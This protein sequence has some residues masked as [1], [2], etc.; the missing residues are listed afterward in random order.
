MHIIH[1][2]ILGIIEGITEFLPISSTGHLILAEKA[3]NFK[4]VQDV[5]TVVVQS[6]AIAAVIWY[7]RNDLWQRIVGLARRER[8]ALV[9]WKLLIIGTV[10]AGVFGLL[11]ESSMEKLTTPTVVAFAL[12]LGGIVLWL[13]DRKPVSAQAKVQTVEWHSISVRRALLVGLGQCVAIIP[14]VSRSGA[15]IVTGLATGLNRPTATALSFYLSIPILLAA[16]ALKVLKHGDAFASIP[17]G[18]AALIVGLVAAFF[19]ALAAVAWL[20]KYV[21][22]HNF[23]S[24]AYYRVLLGIIILAMVSSG[25]L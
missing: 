23:K 25:K 11:L 10:P 12:I 5:F 15:T 16:S 17:G 24:F 14:G 1:A 19:T 4:D 22:H 6:G 20:L 8:Q 7:F 3:L 21:S 9:F 13:V 2:I 18:G